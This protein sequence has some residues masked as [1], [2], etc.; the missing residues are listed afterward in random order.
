M[1]TLREI[2]KRL[3]EL[4]EQKKLKMLNNDVKTLT[5][6]VVEVHVKL[7]GCSN[8]RANAQIVFPNE[9]FRK[10]MK[11]IRAATRQAGNL[12]EALE[13]DFSQVGN[14]A[15]EEKVTRLGDQAKNAQADVTKTW[16][17][18]MQRHLKSYE[19]IAEVGVNLPG[20]TVLEEIMQRL[21][22]HTEKP[23][24]TK[25]TADSI[26]E[27]LAALRE[28]VENLGL[29]G[30]AGKFLIKAAKGTAD[31]R[32]LFKREIKEYFEEKGLWHV[33]AVTIK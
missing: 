14:R 20:G 31:P 29:E 17:T 5:T 32:E 28:S 25:E 16:K 8:E 11:A 6:K 30:E 27:D 10:T 33:L 12:K 7:S 19:A 15:T 26:S 22:Q 1:S 18:L 24:A 3:E 23:P 4:P 9:S 2:T 21:Q 13:K